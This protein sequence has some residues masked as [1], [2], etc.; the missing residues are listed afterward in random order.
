MA[1]LDGYNFSYKDSQIAIMVVGN[2]LFGRNW[3]LPDKNDSDEEDQETTFD[4]DTLPTIRNIRTMLNNI[5]AYSMKLVGDKI[6]EANSEGA[7]ITHA[8][9]AT[10][11]KIVGTFAP[12]GLHIN[13]EEYLPLP[14]LQLSS[15]TTEN[16]AD[17]IK[18]DFKLIEAAS[19]H[20]SE[21]LYNTVDVHMTDATAH[22]KGISKILAKTFNREEEAGQIFC[23][24][25]TVLGFDRSMTKVINSI[26]DSMGMQSIFNSF[27][28]DIDIDQRKETVAISTVSWS[29]S[30]FGPD[31]TQKPWNYYRDF[32]TFMKREDKRVHLFSLKD[33]R[34]GALSK[35]SS[36]MCYHWDDFCSFLES[37]IYITNKLACLVRD[38]LNLDY[39]KVVIAVIAT[40]GVHLI[41]PYHAT[42]IAKTATHSSLKVFLNSLYSDLANHHVNEDFFKFEAPEF[43]AVSQKLFD[44][45][46]KEYNIDVL[47]SVKKIASSHLDDC[48]SLAN[49]MIPQLGDVLAMQRGKY[50]DFGEYTKEYPV[51][52]QCVNID[53]TPVHNLQMERPCG[54]TDY[55]LKKKSS[56]DAATRGTILKQTSILRGSVPSSEF[57]KMCPV[58]QEIAEIKYQ[59]NTRQQ[60]LQSI[61]LDKKEANLLQVENRKLNILDKLKK[62]GGPFTSDEQIQVYLVDSKDPLKVKLSRMKDEVTYAR[63][64]C[65][66]LPKSNPIFRIFNTQGRKRTMLTPE[67]FGN[68]LKILLGKTQ[69]RHTVTL[70]DFREALT[71]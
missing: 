22:N 64:T 45:F 36:I 20:S 15:E 55:R 3:K 63:D 67:D 28:L 42:T 57:R 71:S 17:S 38:A 21:S 50:Y 18:V 44:K 59:W 37:H 61:G 46:K 31:N 39:V 27:L 58:V 66:S 4:I 16:I 49:K 23:D 12:A 69:Q 70:D 65:S 54:D 56:F 29:L 48:I 60:E 62:Q 1:E 53:N 8:T 30:L 25:H 34:F 41:S 26:E 5:Q 32:C 9:D 2:T 40:I 47:N 51:F 6:I 19:G 68:N 11:R 33:A 14:T 43:N 13:K 35:S 10:T 52:D 24:S 7:T